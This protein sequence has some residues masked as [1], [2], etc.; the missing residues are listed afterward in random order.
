MNNYSFL[1]NIEDSHFIF[2]IR[3]RQFDESEGL[4]FIERLKKIPSTESDYVDKGLVEELLFA[5][6]IYHNQVEFF[7]KNLNQDEWDKLH[8][9]VSE[10]FIQT[11]RILKTTA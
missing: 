6:V 5:L 3:N 2:K 7:A 8:S 11:R 4:N 10:I 9:I 1:E